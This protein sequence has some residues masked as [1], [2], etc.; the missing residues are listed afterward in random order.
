MDAARRKT[1]SSDFA[2]PSIWTRSSVFM[3]RLPSCSLYRPTDGIMVQ[4]NIFPILKYMILLGL[5]EINR[6]TDGK[7][8]KKMK[9]KDRSG[10][11]TIVYMIY[12]YIYI[13]TYIYIK[14][15]VTHVDVL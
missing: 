6:L 8:V 14:V 15:R 11:I 2:R 1:R 9:K 4:T 7:K 3:R 13:Y 10:T 12:I 5:K